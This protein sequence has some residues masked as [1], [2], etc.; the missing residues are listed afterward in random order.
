M[1]ERPSDSNEWMW[2][3]P[4]SYM[5][6][7]VTDW[8]S[9]LSTNAAEKSWCHVKIL[10][11][12]PEPETLSNRR[13]LEWTVTECP[14]GAST[15]GPGSGETRPVFGFPLFTCRHTI[16]A[17]WD[18]KVWAVT[19][20]SECPGWCPILRSRPRKS[21]WTQ[22]V[23]NCP[24]PLCVQAQPFL[25]VIGLWTALHVHVNAR[26]WW[27]PVSVG[28]GL[29]GA[30]GYLSPFWDGAVRLLILLCLSDLQQGRPGCEG[31]GSPACLPVCGG[32][33][34]WAPSFGS[35]HPAN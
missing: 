2:T 25:L 16:I 13:G 18:V 10:V 6:F 29:S 3:W 26:V 4:I 17:L 34:G 30:L 9:D 33:S 23:Y 32:C 31:L 12:P 35:I 15:E 7:G 14:G 1:L 24:V 22:P 20:Y 11:P 19:K 21:V 27:S 28:H 5:W 8:E